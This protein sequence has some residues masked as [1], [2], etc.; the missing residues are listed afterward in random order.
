M[1]PAYRERRE[2][3]QERLRDRG[4]NAAIACPGPNLQYFTGFRGEPVDRFHALYLPATGEAIFI[5][6]DG[7][8]TQA[9]ANAEVKDFQPVGGNDPAAVAEAIESFL[10]SRPD[11]VLLDDNALHALAQHLYSVFGIEVVDS[12][13]PVFRSL[14]Q[15][16]DRAEIEAMRRSAAVADAVSN[17]IRALG[18]DAVGMTETELA[19]DIRTKLHRRGAKGVSFDV[20]V[21]A[22]PNGA[23]PALR[24]SDRTIRSAD[25]VVVDFGCFLDGY[26]SDQTRTVIFDGEP[27]EHFEYAY[28]AILEALNNGVA[29]VEPGIT[30][31]D[32]D[33]AVR[34][35]L[36]DYG[37]ADRFI[38]DTGHGV[39]LASHE[40]LVIAE[41]EATKLKSGMVFSIEPGVY[42]KG[43]WGVRIEDLVLV[44]EDDAERLN[45]SPRTWR[46][47]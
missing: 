15:Q 47:L 26:A 16:K 29:T 20:V 25:P 32:V 22:G 41:G 35:T 2:R 6:P 46:P 4:A 13:N 42:F 34:R 14:R 27:P 5:S 43:K 30:A 19:I 9:R 45:M 12:A 40:D 28:D 31:G 1:T 23:D 3:A 21:G 33:A 8:L 10:P 39:G 44:T 37:L 17:E 38:H 11:T 7:Y 18:A 24:H 36:S